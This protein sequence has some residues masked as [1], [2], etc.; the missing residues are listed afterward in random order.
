[1]SKCLVVDK[2]KKTF[3]YVYSSQI[4]DEWKSHEGK[5]YSRFNTDT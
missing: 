1:M 3:A 4:T 5:E 2:I